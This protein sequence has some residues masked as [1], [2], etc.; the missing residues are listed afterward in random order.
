ML[1]CLFVLC[2]VCFVFLSYSLVSI[3]P[4][5][6]AVHFLVSGT[7]IIII[8]HVAWAGQSIHSIR[9]SMPVPLLIGKI[10]VGS[11]R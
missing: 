5:Q 8:I 10:H 2:F 9:D 6:C 3:S 4:F 7:S 1:F 11:S